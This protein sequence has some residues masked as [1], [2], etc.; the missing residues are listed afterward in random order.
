MDA[1]SSSASR[2]DTL[3]A[4]SNAVAAVHH[5][6]CPRHRDG[7]F[8][9]TLRSSRNT[10]SGKPAHDAKDI[11]IDHGSDLALG[12]VCILGDDAEGDMLTARLEYLLV[13]SFSPRNDIA[14]DGGGRRRGLLKRQGVKG[15]RLLN[16][17]HRGRR[18]VVVARRSEDVTWVNATCGSGMF[19]ATSTAQTHREHCM[20]CCLSLAQVYM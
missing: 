7:G 1:R 14:E 19:R 4:L 3:P 12:A 18:R 2:S 16:V 11:L 17:G 15:L 6:L 10:E 9:L 8:L 20:C 13:A 5:Y